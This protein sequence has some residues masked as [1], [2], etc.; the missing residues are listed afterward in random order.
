M[1]LTILLALSGASSSSEEQE[2]EARASK[3]FLG[4]SGSQVLLS[5]LEG[6]CC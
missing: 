5:G 1:I 3:R 6:R 2:K 4:S